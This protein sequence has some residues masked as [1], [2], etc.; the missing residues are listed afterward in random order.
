MIHRTPTDGIRGFL[1]RHGVSRM[2]VHSVQNMSDLRRQADGLAYAVREV[3][4]RALHDLLDPEEADNRT[5]RRLADE[6]MRHAK[7]M[8]QSSLRT[9]ALHAPVASD[10][11][12]VVMLMRSLGDLQRLVELALGLADVTQQLKLSPPLPELPAALRP[13][14]EEVGW[15]VRET[16]DVMVKLDAAAA[17]R[18][19]QR[20]D[21]VDKL[22]HAMYRQVESGIRQDPE[23]VQPYIYLLNA[24]RNLERIADRASDV[25]EDVLLAARDAA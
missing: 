9:L 11:R 13:I 18:V 15:M 7:A 1:P 14:V 5:L 19:Q 8:E 3:V 16:L 17:V 25:A 10:L 21:R 22:Y 24:A 20:D 12:Y 23:L 2:G 6:A 4:D